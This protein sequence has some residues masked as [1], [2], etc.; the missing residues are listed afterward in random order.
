MEEELRSR[1]NSPSR[2]EACEAFHSYGDMQRPEQCLRKDAIC[3]KRPLGSLS[4]PCL[5]SHL[6]GSLNSINHGR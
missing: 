4:A 6:W 1:P 2:R 3:W 5:L